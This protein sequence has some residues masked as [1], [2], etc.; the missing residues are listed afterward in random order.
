MWRLLKKLRIELSYEPTISLLGIHT[1]ETRIKRH[2]YPS[3][4]CSAVYN[5]WDMEATLMSI[6]R[7]MDMEFVLYIHSEIYSAIKRSTFV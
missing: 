5:S 1:E 3:V 2:M 4:H 7:C 6:D